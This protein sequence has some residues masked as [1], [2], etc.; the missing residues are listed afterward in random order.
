MVNK[1]KT[2][3]SCYQSAIP[4]NH[5]NMP[6]K[7]KNS[8]HTAQSIK[9]A[10]RAFANLNFSPNGFTKLGPTTISA[11]ALA[12]IGMEKIIVTIIM[13]NSACF[14]VLATVRKAQSK[15]ASITPLRTSI[16]VIP[17]TIKAKII[18]AV[19]PLIP[20]SIKPV[21]SPRLAGKERI[22]ARVIFP[23]KTPI[24]IAT[25]LP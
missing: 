21:L 24:T 22:A 14:T 6:R 2:F 8:V 19:T 3:T 15:I 12:A 4:Y 16:S 25:I 5:R 10:H 7:C 20:A 13:A 1:T 23:L 17:K 18:A 9:L 11:G